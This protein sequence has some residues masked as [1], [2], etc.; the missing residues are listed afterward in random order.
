MDLLARRKCGRY[1]LADGLFLNVIDE[2]LD[3]LKV[4]V[5]FEQRQPNLAQ[6]LLH[7]LFIEDSLTTQG[8]K[9]A[10]EFF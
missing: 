8:L 9:R 4:D 1:L 6:R 2:L 7:V 3:D 10:L 5:G